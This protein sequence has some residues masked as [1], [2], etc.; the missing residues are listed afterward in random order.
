[1]ENHPK[2]L[3][4]VEDLSSNPD[5]YGR[6][7][8]TGLELTTLITSVVSLDSGLS[9]PSVVFSLKELRKSFEL[10]WIRAWT[11][12]FQLS[13]LFFKAPC[14]RGLLVVEDH[15]SSGSLLPQLTEPIT[16]FF[17]SET[18]FREPPY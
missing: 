9:S 5:S 15:V 8:G 4:E 6:L 11:Y 1:M 16:F 17:G 12:P 10:Q 18:S 13:L 14:L 3:H 2:D 7:Q